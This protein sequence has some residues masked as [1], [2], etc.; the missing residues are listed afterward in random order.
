MFTLLPSFLPSSLPASLPS[1]RFLSFSGLLWVSVAACGL[2]LVAAH[3]LLAAKVSVVA[4]HRPG[5]HVR[6]RAIGGV[7]WALEC[8]GFRSCGS[9]SSWLHSMWNLL[10]PGIEPTSPAVEADSY[11]PCQQGSPKSKLFNMKLHHTLYNILS[12]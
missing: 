4:A 10:R 11:P 7:S 12:L 9:W 2:S 5:E 6:P 8:A 3:S 1:L